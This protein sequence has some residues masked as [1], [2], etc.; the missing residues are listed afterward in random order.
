MDKWIN[1]ISVIFVACFGYLTAKVTLSTKK[2]DV[3]Q[4]MNKSAFD[5]VMQR[6]EVAEKKIL[7]YDS[8]LK[9]YSRLENKYLT[10]KKENQEIKN[11]L[12]AL[13]EK[14]GKIDDI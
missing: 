9:E 14:R 10:L 3:S 13:L 7:E 5:A 12:N 11:Q 1:A 2:V 4:E 6:L 8:L